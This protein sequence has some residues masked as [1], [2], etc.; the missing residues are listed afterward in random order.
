M[1][2]T[3]TGTVTSG[4]GHSATWIP[5]QDWSA[6]GY[7]PWPGTLNVALPEPVTLTGV[8]ITEHKPHWRTG[9][10]RVLRACYAPYELGGL[11]VHVRA[12]PDS[13]VEVVAGCNLRAA[14]DLHDGDQITLTPAAHPNG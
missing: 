4:A 1:N 2:P 7:T 9:Q 11:P 10:P 8:T 12:Y 5:H 6:L 13:R 14:L 3:L